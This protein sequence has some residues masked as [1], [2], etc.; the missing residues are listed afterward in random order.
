MSLSW[1]RGPVKTGRTVVAVRFA[2]CVWLT[3]RVVNR[4]EPW[5]ICLAAVIGMLVYI[6]VLIFSFSDGRS[7]AGR[8]PTWIY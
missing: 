3:V 7:I 8:L 1:R 2:F 4:R 6:E 5:A